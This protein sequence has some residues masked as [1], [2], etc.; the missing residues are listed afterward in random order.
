MMI[1]LRTD[2]ELASLRYWTTKLRLIADVWDAPDLDPA[3]RQSIRPE[4]DNIADRL[5][6]LQA[7]AERGDLRPAA[8]IELQAIT[9]ELTRLAPEM[10]RRRLRVPDLEALQ[11]AVSQ[12][13][14]HPT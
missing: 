11:R 14:A 12:A 2:H 8:L 7:K 9:D 1:D 6:G 13:A 5:A 4:W 10:T 3:A